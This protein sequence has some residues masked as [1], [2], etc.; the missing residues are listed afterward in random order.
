MT[1]SLTPS[2]VAVIGD[3][4]GHV[5]TLRSE[6]TRL[7]ADPRTGVLPA[8][9]VVI[10][11]GDL[12]H[13]GPDSDGVVELVDGYLTEQP[14]NWVQLVGNHEMLYLREPAFLWDEYVAEP[15]EEALI[16]WWR[17]G[18]MR[19]AA[20]FRTP[21]AE[22]LVTH[23]GLTAGMWRAA[24][25]TPIEAATAARG[26]NDLIGRR[27]GVI[28]RGGVMLRGHRVNQG[29]G[30][31]WADAARELVPSWSQTRMSFSQIHGHSTL[32]DWSTGT[33]RAGAPIE[34]VTEIDRRLRHETTTLGGGTIVGIDPCLGTD[35]GCPLRAWES[36]IVGPVV[37]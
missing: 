19:V 11:V 7:G 34:A 13:R 14:N 16:R 27:D 28:A 12:V 37:S 26:L 25:G 17:E 22:Y 2:R 32:T 18:S 29:A 31:L 6:L 20:S 24:L 4:G 8:D 35:G 10:Q 1:A 9:L 36:A 30:P 21:D 33:F 5:D 3:V 23:A 15:T